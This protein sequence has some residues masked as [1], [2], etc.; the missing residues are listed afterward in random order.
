MRTLLTLTFL[1]VLSVGYG[2][3]R[4]T[5]FSYFKLCIVNDKDEVLLVEYKGIW[6]PIGRRYN[7][8]RTIRETLNHMAEEVGLEINHH[9]L[10]AMVNQYYNGGKYPIIFNFWRADY[11]K[12]T[13][14]V[15]AD[16]T[17]IKWVP[18]KE[19]LKLVPFESMVMVM[20]QY[21]VK[22]KTKVWCASIDVNNQ[23]WPH[24]Y[25]TNIREDFYPL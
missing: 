9:H 12:G 4:Q 14:K 11:V 16:C 7:E 2:Q 3:K 13:P 22:D 8:P 5:N 24:S 15:P 23:E 17:D 19:A 18:I 10:G 6:E 20:E 21:L 1:M 25:V